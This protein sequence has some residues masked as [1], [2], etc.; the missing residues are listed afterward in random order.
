MTDRLIYCSK[1][2]KQAEGL[3]QPPIPGELG[4][5]IY[6]E[7]CIE[8]WAQWQHQQ[9][10]LINEHRL[11]MIDPKSRAYLLQ[12]MEKFLFGPGSEPPA[13]YKPKS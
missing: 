8:A 4:K 2:K 7:I 3:P 9:T 6:N 11:S 1:L 13:G 12:E 10:M 5:R